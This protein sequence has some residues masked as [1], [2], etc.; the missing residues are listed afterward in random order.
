MPPSTVIQE[1]PYGEL[2]SA[3]CNF[4]MPSGW[5]E[6]R[7]VECSTL[8]VPEQHAQPEGSLIQ[9]KVTNIK[10]QSLQP[11]PDPVVML[12]GGPGGVG[13]ESFLPYLAE[14]NPFPDRDVII[15]EQRGT[16]ESN[17]A[18]DCPELLDLTFETLN[19]PLS[20]EE[21]GRLNV[22]AAL[23]CRQRLEQEGVN[24]AA[25]NSYEN[26]ADIE[27]LRKALGVEQI[28]LYGVS[29][30]SLL[31]LHT[32]QR[33]PAGLRSV[34]LDGVVP[35]QVN[36][37]QES[38]QTAERAFQELFRACGSDPACARA[39]PELEQVYTEL[40]AAWNAEP[41]RLSLVDFETGRIHPAL[42]DGND[43]TLILFNLLY[44][45]DTIPLIPA[46]I[47]ELKEGR[48]EAFGLFASPILFLRGISW[49]M[50]FSTFCS[51]D[52]D[53]RLEDVNAQG[54]RPEIAEPFLADNAELLQVCA[55][56]DAPAL[57]AEADA[58][59]NS[60]VP[61]LL[62]SGRFDPITPPEFAALAAETLP[63][64][65]QLTFPANGHGAF[66]Y[67]GECAD[68]IVAAFVENPNAP[69]ETGC[70]Q[71]APQVSFVTPENWL[72][73][74]AM[75]RN[76]LRLNG[77][78]SPAPLLLGLFSLTF[79]VGLAGAGFLAW[80]VRRLRGLPAEKR[81]PA[82]LALWLGWGF[83]LAGVVFVAWFGSSAMAFLEGDARWILGFPA[84]LSPLFLVSSLL[85]RLSG[86][87]VALAVLGW[88]QRYW[89]VLG[90]LYYS[91]LALSAAAF[92]AG[93][94]A[95]GLI[96]R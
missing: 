81:L 27:A 72:L 7:Q 67:S 17:P 11:Q 51:E 76:L 8:T 44:S 31:A 55:G 86:L 65:T 40:V 34:V 90:R 6:G 36:F 93:L 1:N 21:E 35:P 33:Y 18:L 38:L 45:G 82:R 32:L 83:A 56:W 15:L 70:L 13:I 96:A 43:L 63:N 57:G 71:N 16:P 24:L 94:A 60:Q 74:P 49:G 78:A 69:V 47:Y 87:M 20:L 59:V 28:N 58:A 95:L 5:E 53:Y 79:L 19:Q 48:S 9:L 52:S 92:A 29:Y 89:S 30:G 26:A 50:Y 62:L 39:Y 22:A 46:L 75:A 42:L 68:S 88:F 85:M 84:S 41:M 25:Y 64:S 77:A 4:S 66:L 10:S 73:S 54:V 14:K 3:P 37:N 23:E 12:Q 91:L 2:V 80:L 61:V